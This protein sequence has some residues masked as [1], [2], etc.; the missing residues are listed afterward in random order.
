VARKP[1]LRAVSADESPTVR[2][3]PSTVAEAVTSGTRRD[4][5]VTMRARI[6]RA[7]DDPNIRG[8]D[9]AALTRRLMEVGKE[10]EALDKAAEEDAREASVSP[11]EDW[12]AS[13]I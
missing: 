3:A 7:I 12:D 9:L 1:S 10:L 8:A 11:D 2:K 13:A 6:A 5:L 4:E